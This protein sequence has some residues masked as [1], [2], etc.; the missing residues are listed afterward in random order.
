VST[1]GLARGKRVRDRSIRS[2]EIEGKVTWEYIGGI[3]SP[4]KGLCSIRELRGKN[5][6]S[7][8]IR[9]SWSEGKGLARKNS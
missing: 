9:G 3:G 6:V 5:C 2:V 1:T 7:D 4:M 8:G